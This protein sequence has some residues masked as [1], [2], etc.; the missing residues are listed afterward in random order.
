MRTAA[1]AF[2]STTACPE[3]STKS[4]TTG[5]KLAKQIGGLFPLGA[6]LYAREREQDQEWWW[7]AL[8]VALGVVDDGVYGVEDGLDELRESIAPDVAVEDATAALS[9]HARQTAPAG[10]SRGPRRARS[11]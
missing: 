6:S 9:L 11:S 1:T 7:V 10:R 3:A 2:T 4:T 8:P 5:S